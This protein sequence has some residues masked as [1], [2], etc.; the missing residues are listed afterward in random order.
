MAGATYQA[1][2][3]PSDKYER[4]IDGVLMTQYGI[5][6]RCFRFVTCGT[7]KA[8]VADDGGLIE[9]QVFRAKAR[10]RRAPQPGHYRG[11]EKYGIV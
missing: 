6:S 7:E 9:V 4:C 5:E 1:L 2:F 8:S 11:R 10:I 3:Q